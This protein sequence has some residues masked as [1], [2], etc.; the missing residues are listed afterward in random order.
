VK[1]SWISKGSSLDIKTNRTPP[2]DMGWGSQKGGRLFLRLDHQHFACPAGDSA[3]FE[4]IQSSG[5]EPE[6]C[7][8]SLSKNSESGL[9]SLGEGDGD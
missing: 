7:V 2:P 9:L 1:W 3:S 6:D 4:E 5:K 8:L